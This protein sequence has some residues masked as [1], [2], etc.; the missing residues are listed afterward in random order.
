MELLSIMGIASAGTAVWLASAYPDA[1]Y[2][3]D[4]GGTQVWEFLVLAGAFSAPLLLHAGV[5]AYYRLW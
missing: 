5:E 1:Y 2:A 3:F 4:P